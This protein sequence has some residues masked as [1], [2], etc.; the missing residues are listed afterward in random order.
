MV[1]N[2]AGDVQRDLLV[3]AELEG[4]WPEL[5]TANA[6]AKAWCAEVNERT[7]SETAAV[8]RERLQTERGVLRPVPLLRPP[9]RHGRVAQ[10]GPPGHGALWLRAVC[11]A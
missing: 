7:H 8:P 6:A 2:L 1:E 4:P 11:G 5:A 3:P 10:G 9:L